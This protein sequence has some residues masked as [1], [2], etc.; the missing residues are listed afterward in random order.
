MM[1]TIRG[2]LPKF[3]SM[4]L[5]VL[6][7][8]NFA[9]LAPEL[10]QW[11]IALAAISLLWQWGIYRQSLPKPKTWLKAIIALSGCLLLLVTGKSLGLLS[12]MLHLLCLSYVLKP[13]EL[14][15]R[16]DLYQ[17]YLIGLLLLSC[18]LIFQQSI[19]FAVIVLLIFIVNLCFL[20]SLF[21]PKEQLKVQF[22]YAAKLL[23]QSVPLAILLFVVFP[24]I[25]PFWQVPQSKGI[26]TG[27]SDTLKIGDISKLALSDKLAFRVEFEQQVP[28]YQQLYW[29]AMVLE[30]FDGKS[31]HRSHQHQADI[32]QYQKVPR[33]RI[34]AIG[35]QQ[36]IDYQVVLTP[37][38][39]P[40][41]FVLDVGELASFTDNEQVIT[42]NDYSLYSQR[43]IT[44]PFAYNVRSNLT[45]PL[46]LYKTR[47]QKRRN[48][49][50]DRASNP[51][52]YQLGQRLQQQYN[53]PQAIIDSVLAQ[54]RLSPFRYTL[55]PP[56]LTNNSLDEFYF[57]TQ[58]GFCEHYAS[59]F[60]FI[61]R[62][63][64]IPARVVLG[65]LGGEL[66]KQ[67][68]YYSV[69]QRDAHAWSEVWFE[70]R[71]WVRVDPTAAVDPSRVEQGFSP[72]LMKEREQLSDFNVTQWL[73]GNL[74]QTARLYL[75]TIDYQWTKLVINY[76]SDTQFALLTSWFGKHIATKTALLI[77]V[78]F[79]LSVGLFFLVRWLTLVNISQKTSVLKLYE[80]ALK[81]LANKGILRQHQETD[82][83]Y[84]KRIKTVNELAS[85][86]FAG[87]L[88]L[89]NNYTFAN[90]REV[91]VEK[92]LKY[93]VGRLKRALKS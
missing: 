64:G 14:R 54:F 7:I 35:E 70:N 5:L 47:F 37:S 2:Q 30:D 11:F 55:E 43:D 42:L 53:D 86:E 72:Q 9:V 23:L 74:L 12:A 28:D 90:Q 56:P 57:S 3:S 45:Q 19:Y 93:K 29:R 40:W 16:Y 63:A 79:L 27:L 66:N 71:G 21:R 13:L 39:Q 62:A 34:A 67:G 80:R 25:P 33:T 36:I 75:D 69:Y 26:E 4:W 65:Y 8:A 50:V 88:V 78:G 89:Y 17:W 81:L 22:F 76:S 15:R 77:L 92:A 85:K 24:K 73:K 52:L 32:K 1:T 41:M 10:T 6:P 46:T 68:D 49:K 18:A 59:S 51:K 44:R 60:T 83:D 91:Q 48:V 84:I 31:W 61:M 58:A 20:A 82:R 38:F 87:I